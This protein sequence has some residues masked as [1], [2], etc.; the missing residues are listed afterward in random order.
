MAFDG[1]K[2]SSP[3]DNKNNGHGA[4]VA[5]IVI[6]NFV[7]N[8]DVLGLAKGTASGTSPKAH[9]ATYKAGYMGNNCNSADIAAAVDEAIK[10]GVD[11]LNLS[12][13][14]LNPSPF[15][16][17]DIII[18]MISTVRAKIFVCMAVGDIAHANYTT[19]HKIVNYFTY[20]SSTATA[21][22]TFNGTNFGARPSPTV[23]YFSSRGPYAYNGGIIKPN[24]L[25]PGA[26]ILYASWPVRPGPNPN[27]PPGSYF[28]FD[29]GTSMATPHLRGIAAL[30]KN[31][32]K[33]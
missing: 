19:T 9:R 16:N 24:I 29:N 11:I 6:G 28:N 1:S 7:D 23:G 30:L 32:H 25:G 5:G 27:G 14:Y 13:G 15:Y 17:D 20:S 8:T 31:T 22:I 33:N 26:N 2:K 12:S 10:N 18:T 4:H 3:K 21:I